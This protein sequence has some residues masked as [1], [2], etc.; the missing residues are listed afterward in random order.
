MANS[1]QARKRARQQTTQRLHNRSLRGAMRTRIRNFL[2]AVSGNDPATATS[3]YREA[4]SAID[5]GAAKGLHHRNTASRLKSRLNKR[6]Q[7]MT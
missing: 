5:R 1:P 2:T 3:T 6:L 4:V 7:G